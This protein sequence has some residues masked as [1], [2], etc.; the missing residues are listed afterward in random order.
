MK[1]ETFII[2]VNK[3]GIGRTMVENPYYVSKNPRLWEKWVKDNTRL[4]VQD[5]TIGNT[6]WCGGG[7]V[8][9]GFYE[10]IKYRNTDPEYGW[11]DWTYDVFHVIKPYEW[12]DTNR[13]NYDD[14]TRIFERISLRDLKNI[15]LY[16]H[17]NEKDRNIVDLLDIQF[18]YKDFDCHVKIIPTEHRFELILPSEVLYVHEFIKQE[19]KRII[20]IKPSYVGKSMMP[21]GKKFKKI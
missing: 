15:R 4:T 5:L 6:T 3:V 13:I 1:Q 14:V 12:W 2:V 8:E 19:F 10:A 20:T 21:L 18:L 7:R 16:R 17:P 11:D 9:E